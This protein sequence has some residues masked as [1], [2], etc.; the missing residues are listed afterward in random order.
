MIS[1]D[2]KISRLWKKYSGK[3]T[4]I[5]IKGYF[6]SHTIDKIVNICKNIKKDEISSFIESID[7][8]FAIV[9]H[10]DDFTF[11]AVDKIRSTPLFFT[12]IKDNFFIDSD[13]KN[14]VNLNSF[15]KIIEENARLEI[16]MSGFVIGNKTIYNN[17]HSLKAGEIVI[18]Q[19]N[20]Y[21]YLQYYKYFGEIINKSFEDYLK[22]L[23]EVTLNIFRKMLNKIGDRQ[24]II[25]LSAGNDSRLVASILKHLGAKNVK[26]YSYG[27][28]ANFEVKIAKIISQKLD[29]EWKFIPLTHK[30]EKFFYASKDYKKYLDYS[31]TYCSV[32]YIQSLST[33]KYLKN[34][35]WINDDAIFINGFSGDFISG[36]HINLNILDA[37]KLEN[38][39]FRKENIL[40]QLIEKHFSLWGYL[41]TDLN[42]INLKV[43]LWNEIVEGCSDIQKNSNDH[44]LY[45]YSEFIDRQSKYVISG[46]RIYEYYGYDWR[47]PLW[48]D[49]YL[50]FW[51]KVPL[52]YK[53][54]QKLYIEMLKKNNF[55][56]VWG[57]DIPVNKKQITPKWIIPLRFICKI[58]FSLF[59]KKGKKAWK[60]FDINFFFYFRDITHMMD[61]QNYIKVIMDIFKRPK[62]NAS[63][64]T[65]DYLKKYK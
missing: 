65:K 15:D 5:W 56:N 19:G 63:W 62:N 8:H 47:L 37:S 30:S 55:G 44:L 46:Q 33:V 45:E 57:D 38:I 61:T 64:L 21:E 23:S 2:I 29:Y 54:K 49:E 22:E 16:A 53:L 48:N 35:N 31:E 9:V 26:C 43:N 3:K 10:K 13:P 6:Y 1:V 60:Q 27:T 32:P 51:Q 12:K 11:I 42:K 41:K 7:G 18:F 34:I 52:N 36:G 58:P 59:G 40:S 4:T 39:E 28:P 14:L 24:I 17:L 50:L 25:P 20:S